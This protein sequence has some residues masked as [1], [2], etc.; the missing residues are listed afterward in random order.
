[1]VHQTQMMRNETLPPY[2]RVPFTPSRQIVAVNILFFASLALILVVAFISMLVK[3]WIREFD[4]GLAAIEK[5]R[6]R[7]LVREYRYL[8]LERWKLLKM[9]HLLP[10]L[11]YFSLFLFFCGL[12]LFLLD[13]KAACGSV[14]AAIFALGVLFYIITTIIATFDDSAP[15]RSPLSRALGH[16]F[17]RLHSALHRDATLWQ[18]HFAISVNTG[19]ASTIRALFYHLAKI[20]R[21]K[22]FSE[23]GF[24]DEDDDPVWGEQDIDTSSAVINKLY[25]SSRGRN[26][27]RELAQS[28]ILAGDPA[29]MVNSVRASFR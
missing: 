15:F 3:G 24:C 18:R 8:G 29:H 17:R 13:I 21:W 12:S 11:I 23:E 14:I 5:P 28:I 7:A 27:S 9:I 10:S 22:P 2:H 20:A 19:Y 16:Y 26:V 25:T 6:R 4:C 1:M